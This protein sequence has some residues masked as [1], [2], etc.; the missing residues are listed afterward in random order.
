MYQ[1]GF[2]KILVI[3]LIVVIAI[4]IGGYF[5]STKINQQ[6]KNN[7]NKEQNNTQNQSN[8]QQQNQSNIVNEDLINAAKDD[9]FEKVQ[10]LIKTGVDVDTRDNMGMTA[11]MY[12]AEKGN[13]EITEELINARANPYYKNLEKNNFIMIAIINGHFNIFRRFFNSIDFDVKTT[14]QIVSAIESMAYHTDW[15]FYINNDQGF[16]FKYPE[17]IDF[18]LLYSYDG[19]IYCYEC[20]NFDISYLYFDQWPPNIEIIS[21]TSELICEEE[22]E[23]IEINGVNFC[24]KTEADFASDA[25]G[26]DH[27]NSFKDFFYRTIK[28]NKEI[29]FQFSLRG[30]SES[31][32]LF[33]FNADK[34]VGN[35]FDTFEFFEKDRTIDKYGTIEG[36]LLSYQGWGIPS[37]LKI[38]AINTETKDEY[39][40]NNQI[41]D[42]KYRYGIGYKIDVPSG[43]YYV[44]NNDFSCKTESGEYY[45]KISIKAGEITILDY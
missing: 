25:L 1:R 33:N 41:E 15:N 13:V 28:D 3:G 21:N 9:D 44:C 34:L 24:K 5:I 2:I 26:H 19:K 36:S 32:P 18:D 38:Y 35:I 22:E 30:I 45:Y 27:V 37:D 40:M 10:E 8:G 42:E 43:D 4:T 11:L 29:K 39:W 31:P 23:K 14:N 17:D 7:Q 12:A 20:S 16:K 6:Q